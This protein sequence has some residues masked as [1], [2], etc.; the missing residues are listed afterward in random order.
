MPKESEIS[1]RIKNVVEAGD[2]LL[3]DLKSN[4]GKVITAG[5]ELKEVLDGMKPKDK[6]S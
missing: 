3:Q 2:K 5:V 6:E 1:R 4:V